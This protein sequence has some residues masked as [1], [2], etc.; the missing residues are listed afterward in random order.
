MEYKFKEYKPTEILRG[1]L[2]LGGSDPA[3]E[4][5]DVTSRYFERGGRPFIPVMGE[6]HFV[7]DSR[8]NWPRELAKMR[9]GGITVVSTYLFWIYHEE[10]E[11]K[12]DFTGDRD[13][14]AFLLEAQRQGLEVVLRLGPWCH[15]EVR[16]G[17]LPDW[18][19]QKPFRLRS[20]DPGYM[21]RAGKWY[22]H[23]FNEVRG[24]FYKDGGPVIGIQIENEL[25]DAPEHL[26]ALKRL[27]Q[28]IGFDAPLWTVTGW[29]S[30]FGAKIPLDEFVPVF[31]GY[32]DAPWAQTAE[33]LP[34]CVHHAFNPERNDAAVGM[35]LLG[36]TAPDGWRLP[37]ERYPYATCELGGG[38]Q[39]THRRRPV[40]SPMDVYAM[41]LVKLGCGN[42]LIGY[43]MFHGGTNKI[44]K[45][46]LQESRATGYPNDVPVLNYD[47]QA[48]ISQ[49]G[50]IREQYRLLNL[51]HLFARDFGDVL[52]PMEHVP[53]EEF[54]PETDRKRLRYAMRTD[55]ESGFVFVN[56]HQRHM[57]LEDVRG[58]RLRPLG[59]EFPPIDVAGDIAFI[60]PFNLKMGSE[61]LEWA[62]A[63]LVCRTDSTYTFAAV[64]GI[65][66]RFKL[67][68]REVMECRGEFD[69]STLFAGDVRLSCL[70]WDAARTLRRL[71]GVL[72]FGGEGDVYEL[73]G[74]L[75]TAGQEDREEWDEE[76]LGDIDVWNPRARLESVPC[77]APFE[78]PYPE[79]LRLGGDRPIRWRRL[80]VTS[81]RGF[82]T[83]ET[84][85]DTAQIYVD[86]VLAADKFFDT[87]PWRIPAAML[88]GRECC[89]AYTDPLEGTFIS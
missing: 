23:I 48:P 85:F 37:Y 86:G 84:P 72:Y 60:L 55:G 67:R 33:E 11:E 17:G 18:L 35:D 19:L 5:I 15:G 73:D 66:P 71:N 62:T 57:E 81:G 49:Y 42:N 3:G 61:T 56:H 32:A 50:E 26:L 79:E 20:N 6:Y 51:L 28:E 14:R 45:T 53:A 7:R 39:P 83:V 54:V 10:E 29:N 59:V 76:E 30:M 2:N 70:S 63:Q 78:I 75:H 52:A 87:L 77:E 40:I 65:P 74:R 36:K 1:H 9:S 27:A 22:Q 4:R 80:R 58:V 38:I 41:S 82:V 34:P 44:G 12:F 24:L 16:N 8:E 13:V 89:L 43:Y 69:S 25:V 68:G 88:Y 47:F 46:T 21:A 64:P 31:G